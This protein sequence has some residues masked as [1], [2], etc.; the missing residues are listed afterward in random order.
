ML[1]LCLCTPLAYKRFI[2]HTFKHISDARQFANNNKFLP[3][4]KFLTFQL[5]RERG[6]GRWVFGSLG[7]ERIYVASRTWIMRIYMITQ[8]CTETQRPKD[9]RKKKGMCLGRDVVRIYY[10]YIYIYI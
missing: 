4:N 7:L 9:P 5:R 6:I 3:H 10:I 8:M 1:C 2:H